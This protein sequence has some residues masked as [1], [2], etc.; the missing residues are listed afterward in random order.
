MNI[1]ALVTDT[2]GFHPLSISIRLD[3]N[4]TPLI[5]V[6][7]VARRD[8]AESNF[9]ENPQSSASRVVQGRRARGA[10][11]G[12]GEVSTRMLCHAC[13]SLD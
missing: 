6:M 4:G 7:A 9:H 1:D 13:C 12:G 10:S 11:C 2:G 3:R 8:I 5:S